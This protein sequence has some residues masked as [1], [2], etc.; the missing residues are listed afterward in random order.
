MITIR[1]A[2]SAAIPLVVATAACSGAI[3]ESVKRVEV[4]AGTELSVRLDETL[5]TRS[6]RVGTRFSTTVLEPVASA[7]ATSDGL[8]PIPEGAK[9]MGEVTAVQQDPPVLKVVFNEIEVRGNRYPADLTLISAP[10]TQHSEMKDEGAKIGGGAA[11][12]ALIGGVVGGDVKGVVL[13]AAAGAAAG[14]AVAL[15][16]KED[17]AH[18]VAGTRMSVRLEEPL[19]LPVT[20]DSSSEEGDSSESANY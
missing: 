19:E 4:P 5:D 12:G 16:T 18:L 2:R 6:T 15:A 13:G 1:S 11:A 8:V 9:A 14:T 20:V 3:G 7:E 17:Y 10:V